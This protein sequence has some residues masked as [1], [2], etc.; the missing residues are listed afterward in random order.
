[1]RAA[2]RTGISTAAREK[3]YGSE[4]LTGENSAVPVRA[5]IGG[6][7]RLT[8]RARDGGDGNVWDHGDW[9]AATVHCGAGE[10]DH[11]HASPLPP[12]SPLPPERTPARLLATRW[13][14]GR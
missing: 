6:A 5:P 1:M 9:G 4:V 11:D 10:A 3:V 14:G 7:E 2:L 12:S 8:L 13:R